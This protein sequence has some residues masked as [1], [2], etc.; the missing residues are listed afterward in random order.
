[1]LARKARVAVSSGRKR[2]GAGFW[3]NR[4]SNGVGRATTLD[5]VVVVIC[6]LA[7]GVSGKGW[8]G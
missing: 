3:A 6:G 5:P 4:V 1:M 8:E 7:T 2:S